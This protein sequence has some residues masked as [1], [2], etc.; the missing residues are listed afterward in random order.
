M[1]EHPDWFNLIAAQRG[2]PAGWSWFHS[3]WKGD[4]DHAVMIV[5]GG[6][7]GHVYARGPNKGKPNPKKRTDVSEMIVTRDNLIAIKHQWQVKTGL[8]AECY[9]EGKRIAGVSMRDGKT[10]RTYRDCKA[11]GASGKAAL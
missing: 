8:C 10:E 5:K 9:G 4:G 7:A 1:N 3:E 11:C 6:V 2:L